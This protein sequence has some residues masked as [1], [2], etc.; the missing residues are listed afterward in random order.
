MAEHLT[1]AAAHPWE[2]WTFFTGWSS[3]ETLSVTLVEPGL[4]VEVS[5][6]VARDGAAASGTPY[7]CCAY[8]TT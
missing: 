4:V 6:D 7:A 1:A 5:A 3:R 8:V 2:G